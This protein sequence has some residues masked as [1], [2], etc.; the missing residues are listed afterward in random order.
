MAD[1]FISYSRHDSQQALAL[2]EQ[3]RAN[4]MDVWIDQHGIE[5]A[6]SW[7]K[8]IANAL[9]ACHTML[10]LLSP[11]AIASK[12]VAKELSVATQL[13]KRI[14]PVQVVHVE[15]EGEFLYHLSGLQR[16][17]IA[18]F[19]AIV[20]AITGSTQAERPKKSSK[21][22]DE[23]KSLMILPFDDLS[24]TGDN[25][26]FADGI[27]SEMISALSYVKALRVTDAATTKDFRRYHG[28]LPVYAAE[29]NIR[30]FVQG[31]V[32][33]F[34]DNI[35]ISS[36]LLD[37]ETGEHL[38]Q[39]SMKGTMNDIF[40]IQEQVAEKVVD[41]LKVHLATEEK[42]KLS[43]R[44]TE[45]AEAYELHMRSLDYFNRHT[46]EG[47]LLCRQL[48]AEALRLDPNYAHAHYSSAIALIQ[49]YRFYDRTPDLLE[50]AETHC[51]E[52][53][54]LKPDTLSPYDLLSQIY[55]N[56]GQL[57]KAEE[58]VQ[59]FIRKKPLSWYSH[60]SLGLFYEGTGQPA[61]AIAPLEEAVRLDPE[62][63]NSISNLVWTCDAAGETEKCRQWAIIA[64]PHIERSLKLQPDDE[65]KHVNYAMMLLMSGKTESARLEAMKLTGLK[66]GNNL[67]NVSCL[68]SK[69]GDR[70][71]AVL[72]LGKAIEA[73]F[74]NTDRLRQFL[75][76]EKEGIVALAGTPEYE[77]VKRMV[78]QIEVQAKAN[79]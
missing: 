27:V 56:R 8:E 7:S 29:M 11:T 16:V 54:R 22:V 21:P 34:G 37:I 19:D 58:F 75:A 53:L 41:G 14:L 59:E 61:K 45:N 57:A 40:D 17:K 5:G 67:Y 15:L 78:E 38:W 10:L 23:R 39:D 6:T 52:A 71:P 73:G 79:G 60:F 47:F 68:L 20:R 77:E 70:V 66:D 33:K 3:L 44:G 63:A 43:E 69:L 42:K 35:K 62:R 64:L 72:T 46:K 24:S 55:V 50:S 51:K 1:I 32:R 49:L 76:D 4:G 30:Y 74:K 18:D 36:R 12:N 65:S 26:W 9:Q 2:A 48:S 31:D 13:D 25:Q 28:T